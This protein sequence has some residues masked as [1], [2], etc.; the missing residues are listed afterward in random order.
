MRPDTDG[1]Q[2]FGDG[3]EAISLTETAEN[4]FDVCSLRL[5]GD[6]HVVPRR[7]AEG[8][9]GLQ[10]ASTVFFLHAALD[11]FGKVDGIVFVHGLDQRFHKDSQLTLGNGLTDGNNLNAK[12]L[13]QD[14]FIK[15]RVIPVPGKPGELPEQNRVKG[16][17][18]QLGRADQMAEGVPARDLSPGNAL[19]Y[20]YIFIGDNP[21]VLCRPLANLHQLAGRGQLY[22]VLRADP[23]VRGGYLE[24][25]WHGITA[26]HRK[27]PFPRSPHRSPHRLT[28]RC[29]GGS[30]V[31]I[32]IYTLSTHI[33]DNGLLRCAAVVT[34]DI[35]QSG[36]P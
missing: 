24:F 32:L 5:L 30:V 19:V 21:S 36:A 6:Q 16:L 1:V 7:I 22:L 23:D 20:K 18:L 4:L 13:A 10:L 28:G 14:G 15:N 2:P 25:V 11:F 3:V 33:D 27:P 9:V 35:G 17:R 29:G 12:L 31:L 34:G 8:G 26:I